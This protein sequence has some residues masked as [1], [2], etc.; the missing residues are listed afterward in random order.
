VLEEV[1]ETG[2]TRT[3]VPRTNV[4]SDRHGNHGRRGILDGDHAEAVLESGFLEVHPR[5]AGGL[6]LPVENSERADKY[7]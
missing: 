2:A 3:F 1:G 4:V 6:S 7:R 5:A